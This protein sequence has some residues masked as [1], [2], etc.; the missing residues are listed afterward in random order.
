MSRRCLGGLHFNGDVRETLEALEHQMIEVRVPLGLASRHR[1][2]GPHMAGTR[3][4]HMQVD[5][6][7]ATIL[8]R[9]THLLRHAAV[10]TR[11][12]QNRARIAPE[13]RIKP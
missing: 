9:V 1:R 13:S 7:V 2:D 10:G 8:D 11:I 12:E 3:P 4:P 5:N 6:L